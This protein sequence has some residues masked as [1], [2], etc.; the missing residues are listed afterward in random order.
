MSL[1]SILFNLL[2][3]PDSY[4]NAYL[5]AKFGFDTAS[6]T[7]LVKFARSPRAQIPQVEDDA[8]IG[9]A[10]TAFARDAEEKY[11]TAM[12]WYT[13]FRFSSETMCTFIFDS[14]VGKSI[15]I[16]S[17]YQISDV[18]TPIFGTN[19]QFKAFFKIQFVPEFEEFRQK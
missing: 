17:K 6:R 11:Q 13:G 2:F 8:I 4:S 14:A 1:F 7:S 5:V 3:E 16:S 9:R 19:A 10:A 15:K 12:A 18:S